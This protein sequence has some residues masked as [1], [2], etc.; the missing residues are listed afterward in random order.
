M[1]NKK[2]EK[3][4]KPWVVSTVVSCINYYIAIISFSL[5]LM[6]LDEFFEIKTA[7][8]VTTFIVVS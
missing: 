4:P 6:H 7:L 5:F 3:Q 8:S 2:K 1:D